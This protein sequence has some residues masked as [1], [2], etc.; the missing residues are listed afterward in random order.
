MCARGR[1]RYK[2]IWI[3]FVSHYCFYPVAVVWAATRY[4]LQNKALRRG[5]RRAPA[6]APQRADAEMPGVEVNIPEVNIPAVTIPAVNIQAVNILA[7]NI[8]AVNAALLDVLRQVKHRCLNI[9]NI[10]LY[11]YNKY[12]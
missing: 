11:I 12:F 8:Q 4:K 10:L 2:H 9:L 5:R 3:S 6:A 1:V 7:V